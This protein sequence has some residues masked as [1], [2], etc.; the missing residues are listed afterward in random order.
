MP[1]TAPHRD[2]LLH[3]ASAARAMLSNCAMCSLA[4]G[5][6]RASGQHTPC[7]LSAESRIFRR[8]TSFAEELDLI[9]SSMLYFAGCN[10][11]CAFCVQAPSCFN[12]RAGEV[13]SPESLAAE[14]VE[15][16]R[17]GAKTINLLGGEPSLH[18]HT[19]LEVAAAA[20]PTKLPLVLNSN[21]SMSPAVLQLFDGVIDI[22]LADLKFGNDRCAAT[23]AKA[24]DYFAHTTRNLLLAST[25]GRVIIRY[26]VMPG[27]ND[28]C[29]RPI[30]R[31]ISDFLP[32]SDF[33]L[34]SGYVP[35]WQTARFD[36]GPLS[37]VATAQ[38]L[39]D[40]EQIVDLAR[41][42]RSAV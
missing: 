30:A 6:D 36:R 11:R 20:W 28:C 27:H 23:I 22:Y 41:L 15:A 29:L 2:E 14:C 5:A 37:R 21:F 32:D 1:A 4:C 39:A 16:V 31:W 42:R 24:P 26:L 13:V 8:Y 38:E 12:P 7:G 25:Q 10:F 34:M 17:R 3:R 35:A 18:A 33:T 40:A 9:P 19:I